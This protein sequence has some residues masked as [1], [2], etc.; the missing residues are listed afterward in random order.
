MNLI[1]ID[2]LRKELKDMNCKAWDRCET[3]GELTACSTEE[4]ICYQVLDDITE[5]FKNENHS[6]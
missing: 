5:L 2:I 3:C 4:L 1:N 6:Y